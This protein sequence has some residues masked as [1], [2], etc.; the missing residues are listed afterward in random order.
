MSNYCNVKNNCMCNC[1]NY[2]IFHKKIAYISSHKYQYFFSKANVVGVGVGYKIT[3][4]ITTSE[5]CLM[6]FVSKK[7]P[8]SELL[9]FNLIPSYYDGV[10]TDVV[11]SGVFSIY[12]QG[13]G[14]ENDLNKR[15]R[16]A[17]GGCGIGSATATT[18]GTLGCV[19]KDTYKYYILSCNH[20]LAEFNTVP[21]GIPVL[22]PSPMDGGKVSSDVIAHLSKYVPIVK[23]SVLHKNNNLVDCA[24]AEI[25]DHSN[26]TPRLSDGFRVHG[27]YSQLKLMM[28]V[29]KIGKRTGLNYGDITALNAS[30]KVPFK[31]GH[32]ALFIDQ[33]IANCKAEGGDS[34]AIVL[35]N[36]NNTVGLICAASSGGCAIN[37]IK[38]VLSSLH[39]EIV[40]NY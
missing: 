25:N 4:G 27:P 22:Q 33:I 38:N 36:S 7:V 12:D 21:I 20:V 11:E 15:I 10:K 32:S 18:T 17:P 23:E 28:R 40:T 19:V 39:V 6:V 14:S 37:D 16:P 31:G 24:I 8:F 26:V 9:S 2:D 5:K 3:N 1:C 13:I 34:G 30:I 29:H 35:D